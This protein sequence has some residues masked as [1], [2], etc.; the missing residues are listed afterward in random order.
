MHSNKMDN[1]EQKLYQA[2]KE[3]DA[4]LYL[5]S[6]IDIDIILYLLDNTLIHGINLDRVPLCL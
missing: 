4:G 1:V 5:T 6:D 3:E 2:S